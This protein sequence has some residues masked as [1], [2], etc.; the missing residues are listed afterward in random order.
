MIKENIFTEQAIKRI[1]DQIAKELSEKMETMDVKQHPVEF[2]NDLGKF[3]VEKDGTTYFQSAKT[4]E[5][6]DID[7]KLDK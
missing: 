2:E 1:Q 3:R 5:F 6:I 4:L 7:I